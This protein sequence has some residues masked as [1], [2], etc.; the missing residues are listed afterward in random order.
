V[1]A[2]FEVQW[3][4][5]E[6]CKVCGTSGVVGLSLMGTNNLGGAPARDGKP[7]LLSVAARLSLAIPCPHCQGADALT[8]RLPVA[9]P[10]ETPGGAA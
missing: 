2:V 7:R 1:T 6:V 4:H 3:Q 9:F 8:S 5:P 10:V